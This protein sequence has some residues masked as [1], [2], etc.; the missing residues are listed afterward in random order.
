MGEVCRADSE[1][2]ENLVVLEESL[3][4][5]EIVGMRKTRAKELRFFGDRNG[6]EK[7]TVLEISTETVPRAPLPVNVWLMSKLTRGRFS[8]R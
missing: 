3:L 2:I 1:P 8:G 6:E 7:V 4:A 5:P